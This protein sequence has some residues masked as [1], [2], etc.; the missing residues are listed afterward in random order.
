MKF[1]LIITISLFLFSCKTTFPRLYERCINGYGCEQ[2]LLKSNQEFES[3]TNFHMLGKRTYIGKWEKK[4]DTITLNSY[5]SPQD[6]LVK[7]VERRA[8]IPGIIIKL[9]NFPFVLVKV[10]TDTTLL[11]PINNEVVL[12]EKPDSFSFVFISAY[13]LEA[14][15]INFS[16]QDKEANFFEVTFDEIDIYK[17]LT[18]ERYIYKKRKLFLIH[19]K[20]PLHKINLKRKKW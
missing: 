8:S 16:I 2:V 10:G 5:L 4:K 13:N 20:G 17:V 14:Y 9:N 12:T 19:Y 6:A 18:N 1:L 11:S 3:Y 7:V 15:P